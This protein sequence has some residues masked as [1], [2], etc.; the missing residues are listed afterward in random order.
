MSMQFAFDA[1][2]RVRLSVPGRRES[3]KNPLYVHGASR[4]LAN[5]AAPKPK[6]TRNA[7]K[8]QASEN[9][10]CKVSDKRFGAT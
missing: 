6:W 7:I 2:C 4:K 8:R 3:A 5:S 1:T 10:S 9:N